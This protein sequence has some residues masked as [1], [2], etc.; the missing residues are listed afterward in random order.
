[1]RSTKLWLNTARDWVRPST[2]RGFTLT[3]LLVVISII[4]ILAGLLL[5]ALAKAKAQATGAQ[6]LG[7]QRQLALAWIM[8]ADE[9]N[10]AL[11]P[12]LN[13]Y[14]PE[15]GESQY[16]NGGGYWPANALVSGATMLEQRQK[17]IKLGP[18]F[19]YSPNVEINHCPGDSRFKLPMTARNWA[20]DSYAKADGMNGASR[21]ATN[22]DLGYYPVTKQS[23]V[24]QP[25]RMYVF[26]EEAG[27]G[28]YNKGTWCMYPNPAS[29]AGPQAI[30]NV[31]I[32]HNNKSTVGFADGHGELH[33][34]F[35]DTT[36]SCGRLA[37]SGAGD[38][39]VSGSQA[40]GTKDVRYMG[41]G[42]CFDGWPPAW[43]QF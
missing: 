6:C 39:T 8:Y 42:Y 38:G 20:Y 18:L 2:R 19:K 21:I 26:V 43:L 3:E 23:A 9:Y 5:P 22:F 31:A 36:L 27:S 37:A 17:Q 14:I 41:A 33:K 11:V 35:D 16:M 25:S 30:N 13:V 40:L 1:M 28:G 15:L 32:F 24:R 29:T 7:N 34:W 10:G 12:M 4:A